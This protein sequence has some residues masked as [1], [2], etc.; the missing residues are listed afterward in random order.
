M[1]G[2]MSYSAGELILC[3]FPFSSGQQ[4]KV[5]PAIMVQ[6]DAYNQRIADT[7]LVSITTQSRAAVTEVLL[8]PARESASGLTRPSYAVCNNFQT[9]DQGLIHSRRGSDSPAR[10]CESRM[11]L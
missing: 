2:T 10:T 5:R 7:V 9:I 6:N 3:H 4:S 8:D 11:R 1:T